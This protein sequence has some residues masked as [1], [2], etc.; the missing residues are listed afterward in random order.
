MPRVGWMLLCAVLTLCG[1]ARSDAPARG[2]PA[3][4]APVAV[5]THVVQ[6]QPWQDRLEALGT[7]KANES[8]TLTAK[9]TET[10]VRV[11]FDDGDMIEAGR[12]LVDLSGRAEVAALDEAQANYQEALQQYQRQVELVRQG[13]LAKGT[14][15]TLI[16]ARDAAKARADAIRARLADRVI[17]APFAGLLGFRQVSPGTLVTPGTPIATLDDISIIK[18]DFSLPETAIAAVQP[19]QTVLARSAAFPGREFAGTVRSLDARVDPV[20][21]AIVVRAE[22]PNPD[23]LLRPGMLL[24]VELALA[25]RQALAIPEIALIQVGTQQSV[26]RVGANDQVEQVPVR[27]GARRRGEVEIVDGLAAGDRIVIEGLVKLR[28]G[29]RVTEANPAVAAGAG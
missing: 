24:N 26:F 23:A 18:L 11:N 6:A 14:L 10:V 22:L 3:A 13:T 16:A 17:S 8:V 7:A 9:V 29:M 20:T 21:R 27:G 15:D 28:T 25:E 12:W 5:V 2:A 19:G 4:A 1:C